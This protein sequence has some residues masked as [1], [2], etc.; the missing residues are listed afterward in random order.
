[1]DSATLAAEA[2]ARL[3]FEPLPGQYLLVNALAAFITSHGPRD[4]FVLNGYAGTG[5][6]SLVGA[7]VKAMREAKT[8]LV[9]LAPTG[10]AAKVASHFSGHAAS[11]IHKRLF[12]GNSLDPANSTFFIAPNNDRDTV[13][14]VDEA[15]LIDDKGANGLLSLLTRH[16]YS[17][18]G[19]AMVLVGDIAQLPPVGMTDSPA[20]NADRLRQLG[21]NPIC[22]SLDVTVRQ[23]AESGIL[24]NATIIR[25][26]MAA[27]LDP[28]RFHLATRGMTDF[29]K[30]SSRDLADAL[31]DSWASVGSDETLIIT[32]SNRRAN[33]Y[34]MA[35]RNLVMGADSPL[36][37]GDRIII[38][39][40][41][42]FWS[43]RNKLPHFIANGDSAE[44]TWVGKTE[45]MYGRYFT[46][47]E[48][49]LSG[50]NAV[51]G[52]KVMLRSLATEGASIPREEMERLYNRVL[53]A[54]EGEL[55]HKIL[56]VMN[57]EYYN[58]LQVKYGYCVTCHK[59][60][61]GQWRHVY[62]DMAN[63]DPAAIGEDFYRWIY[64]SVTR[65]TEKVFLINPTIP[66]R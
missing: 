46:D 21:L 31:A 35:I 59:A 41:D 15:S 52:A 29:V 26:A 11:T 12:R 48:L 32:R 65:A 56:G 51:V 66:C 17:A 39:K 28:A 24:H 8:P 34:N 1:M 53:D 9:M 5:K 38:A 62:I 3:G 47:V 54:Y 19:C 64:T 22:H 27:Q 61:G 50:D 43:R 30:I 36:Q 14:F 63:I 4:V 60:Q 55:S 6:T 58:A 16:V 25:Q 49:R 10:R 40:N 42:Y 7:M 45:K 23:A 20:M 2:C 57:D 44:V 13:F 37:R 33:N 18:P